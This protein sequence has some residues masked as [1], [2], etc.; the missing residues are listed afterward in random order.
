MSYHEVLKEIQKVLFP[1][2]NDRD[3]LKWL[4]TKKE[5]GKMVIEPEPV[6]SFSSQEV[7]RWEEK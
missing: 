5:K 6:S 7:L 3:W 2:E 1:E 4:V